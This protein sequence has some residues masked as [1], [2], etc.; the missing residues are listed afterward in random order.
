MDEVIL[1]AKFIDQFL[2]HVPKNIQFFFGYI[3]PTADEKEKEESSIE[4]KLNEMSFISIRFTRI[5]HSI[6]YARRVFHSNAVYFCMCF[7]IQCGMWGSC[8]AICTSLHV[9]LIF[10][11]YVLTRCYWYWHLKCICCCRPMNITTL[12]VH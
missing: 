11:L 7:N 6:A 3:Q 1:Q 4:W 8:Y 2:F 12:C 5:S 9:C 10:M